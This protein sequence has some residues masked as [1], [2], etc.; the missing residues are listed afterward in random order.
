VKGLEN[1]TEFMNIPRWMIKHGYSDDEIAKIVGLN[2]LKLLEK[3]W[4]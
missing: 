2:A 1:L 3:V 4:R